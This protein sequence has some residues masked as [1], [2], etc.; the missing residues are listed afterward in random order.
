MKNFKS[1][2]R[3]CIIPKKSISDSESAAGQQ[4][5]ET[6][7]EEDPS[8][9]TGWLQLKLGSADGATNRYSDSPSSIMHKL[10]IESLLIWSHDVRRRRR[11]SET[12]IQKT[13]V[14]SAITASYI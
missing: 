14:A 8:Q 1:I 11:T 2:F 3:P 13:G 12:Y 5:I 10:S 6:E 9:F 4:K 7:E